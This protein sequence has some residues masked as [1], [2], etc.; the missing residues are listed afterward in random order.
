[1]FSWQPRVFK[2]LFTKVTIAILNK[3][4]KKDILETTTSRIFSAR[5]TCQVFPP[6][7]FIKV[8]GK[9]TLYECVGWNFCSWDILDL[10]CIHFKQ[11]CFKFSTFSPITIKL[12]GNE[13][14]NFCIFA[15]LRVVIARVY[16]CRRIYIIIVSLCVFTSIE[17]SF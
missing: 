7:F 15:S 9:K 8:E 14:Q 2:C 5:Y 10:F 3:S 17:A 6:V 11:S 12:S 16:A 1:M 4:Y 13:L